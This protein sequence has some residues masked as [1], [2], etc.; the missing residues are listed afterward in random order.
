[1]N[2][3]GGAVAAVLAK[4][5]IGA[6]EMIVVHDDLDLPAGSVRLKR[7]G[8]TGGH[9]GLRSLREVLGTGDFCRVRIG[10]GRPP[11]GIDA[12]DFVLARVPPDLREPFDGA[13]ADAA[14]AV[15]AIVKEGFDKAATRWNA[16]RSAPPADRGE[17]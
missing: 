9:N 3:S 6:G 15:R 2:L 8:G 14:A 1:M 7:G 12:A 13:V 11:E 5:R 10:I 17:E 4:R 16:R